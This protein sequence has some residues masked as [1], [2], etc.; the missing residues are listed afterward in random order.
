MDVWLLLISSALTISSSWAVWGWLVAPMLR[1]LTIDG[2]LIL[3]LAANL[4]R[5]VGAASLS[6]VVSDDF[7]VNV[8]WTI[9]AFDLLIVVVALVGIDA[10]RRRLPYARP[11]VWGFLAV[12]MAQNL[13]VGLR[14]LHVASPLGRAFSTHWY[15][16]VLV[17]PFLLFNSLLI[18]LEL[19]KYEAQH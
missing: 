18:F 10:I 13:A 16:A 5:V 17:V 6:P 7:L 4:V 1:R 15:V 12:A 2:R 9:T 8:G 3:L 19:R 14:L 11:L